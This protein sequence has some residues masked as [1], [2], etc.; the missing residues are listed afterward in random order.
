VVKIQHPNG[1]MTVYAH[2]MENLVQVGDEVE[3][4]TVIATVGRTG[5]AT[6][7][8]LHFEIRRDGMA[9]NPM[10]LLDSRD[11]PPILVSTASEP[12]VAEPMDEVDEEELP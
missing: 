3:A 2:N 11:S 6:A 5:R 1:F 8:H 7:Q 4:G 10:F 9:F 12:M